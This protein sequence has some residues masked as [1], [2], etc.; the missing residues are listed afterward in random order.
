VKLAEA[1]RELAASREA[2]YHGDAITAQL[3]G[4]FEAF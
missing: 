4:I 3:G 2:C 1:S